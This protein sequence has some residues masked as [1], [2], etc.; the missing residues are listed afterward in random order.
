M[1]P[2]AFIS[3][4]A[5]LAILAATKLR[6]T[7][8][9]DEW[10]LVVRDGQLVRAGVGIAISRR[11]GDVIARFTS[12]M[13]RV[14]FNTTVLTSGRVEMDVEG[15]ILWSVDP[16]GDAPFHAY[17]SLGLVNLCDGPSGVHPRHLLTTPQHRAL[18]QLL[19]A[20]LR[21]QASRL[22]AAE[23]MAS[24]DALVTS[25]RS[26]LEEP[27]R[28]L[29]IVISRVDVLRVR[30]SDDQALAAMGQV[31]AERL[32]EEAAGAVRAANERM[33]LEEIA[34]AARISEAE[35][36]VARARM[37]EDKDR[38]LLA[39]AHD[40]E[41]RQRDA[42]LAHEAELDRDR[43]QRELSERNRQERL[44][45]AQAE[46]MRR[47]VRARGEAEASVVLASAAAD[48]SEAVREDERARLL[49]ETVGGALRAMPIRDVRWVQS[50]DGSPAHGLTD[51]LTSLLERPGLARPRDLDA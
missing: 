50:S 20:S 48:K 39:L 15:F 23:V 11:P 21:R 2:L 14:R 45:E 47:L 9:P 40:A 18:R 37:E 8:R 10:L 29:G 26:D 51:M 38:R 44:R 4:L 3:C 49:I 41:V 34:C 6:V 19:I 17:R 33:K 31:A 25:F 30:P 32:R 1:I 12:T 16:R 22:G 27:E 36:Y 42:I 35:T 46:E 43:A 7:A 5:G 28:E 24:Q 13:Q